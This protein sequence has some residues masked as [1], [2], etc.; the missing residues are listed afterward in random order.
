MRVALKVAKDSQCNALKSARIQALLR[1]R[2][3]SNGAWSVY[4]ESKREG[5]LDLGLA[6]AK[7]FVK[8]AVDRNRLKR[9]AR[10]LARNKTPSN[11]A[12]LVIRLKQPVGRSTRARLRNLE[13]QQLKTQ[14]QGLVS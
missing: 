2:P 11:F 7:K 6:I 12:E 10:E 3:I 5:R 14:L 4:A 8:R 13:Y 1:T 9:A